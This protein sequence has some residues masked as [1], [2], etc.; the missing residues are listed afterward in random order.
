MPDCVAMTIF[1]LNEKQDGATAIFVIIDQ[2]QWFMIRSKHIEIRHHFIRILVAKEE[3][4]LEA[5]GYT[6][7]GITKGNVL[8]GSTI[9]WY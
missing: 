2:I 4:K 7:Q 1:D 8:E 6:Y 5:S 3:V 9:V